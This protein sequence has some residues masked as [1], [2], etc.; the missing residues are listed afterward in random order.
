MICHHYSSRSPST[1]PC[2]LGVFWHTRGS[3]KRFSMVKLAAKA[4]LHR[5]LDEAPTVLVQ[6]CYKTDQTR[7]IVRSAVADVLNRELPEEGYDRVLFQTKCDNVFHLV[8]DY[9]AQGRRCA[10]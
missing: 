10:N 8:L 6:D 1:T 5:L 7:L 4:L 2:K 9:A 3:D